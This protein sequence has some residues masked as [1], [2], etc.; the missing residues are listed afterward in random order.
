VALGFGAL[1]GWLSAAIALLCCVGCQSL[2][3]TSERVYRDLIVTASLPVQIPCGALKDA[4]KDIAKEP[5]TGLPAA[6]LIVT[7]HTVKHSLAVLPYA[8][9]L[10]IFPFHLMAGSDPIETYD[11]SSFPYPVAS[12]KLTRG[13]SRSSRSAAIVATFPAPII[14][15]SIYSSSSYVESH[16]WWQ[17]AL[18]VPVQ[19]PASV[20]KNSAYVLL[21]GADLVLS[22]LYMPFGPA[23][24]R[25]YEWESYPVKVTAGYD[26]MA[27]RFYQSV[28]E[29]G[30]LPVRA[31][32]RAVSDTKRLCQQLPE[33]G[34]AGAPFYYPAMA[35]RHLWMGVV[36]GLIAL[37]HPLVIWSDRF[38]PF[39]LYLRDGFSTNPIKERLVWNEMLALSKFSGGV[40]VALAA[41]AAE[42]QGQAEEANKHWEMALYLL[43]A[44]VK[45]AQKASD[46]L[47]VLHDMLGRPG[48]Y[49]PR[50]SRELFM[51]VAEVPTLEEAEQNFS[52]SAKQ[53]ADSDLVLITR[54]EMERIELKRDLGL[55]RQI[56]KRLKAVGTFQEMSPAALRR[57]HARSPHLARVL[58]HLLTAYHYPERPGVFDQCLSRIQK[59]KKA[60]GSPRMLNTIEARIEK[61]RHHQY[62]NDGRDYILAKT[63]VNLA[64]HML[65]RSALADS[66]RAHGRGP[67]RAQL[68]PEAMWGR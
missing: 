27:N 53:P 26:N 54:R 49:R 5:W 46:D 52:T 51:L 50:T 45:D 35:G 28:M 6:P 63:I 11:T 13:A 39:D 25:I 24:A 44:S 48:L 1:P 21:H 4:G 22:P 9:D 14:A 43:S 18:I 47:K 55:A 8:L 60:A 67:L 17:S 16:P 68:K 31:P 61:C 41:I 23:P 3:D 33:L 12:A 40:V 36:H 20:L 30:L 32:L 57:A 42:S 2:R 58:D 19:F 56:R 34:A 66:A 29:F 62:T 64:V 37:T 38:G 10:A 59:A 7:C 15:N 65:E